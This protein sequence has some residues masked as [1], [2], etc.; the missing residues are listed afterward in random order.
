M[1][2]DFANISALGLKSYY[3]TILFKTFILYLVFKFDKDAFIGNN[4]S[5]GQIKNGIYLSLF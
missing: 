4:F 2:S 5:E 1:F 3:I